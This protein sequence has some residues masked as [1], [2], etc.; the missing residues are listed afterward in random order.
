MFIPW[1][2][3][4]DFTLGS[5]GLVQVTCKLRIRIEPAECLACHPHPACAQ[6]QERNLDSLRAGVRGQT[7]G[8]SS[9]AVGAGQDQIWR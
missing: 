4:L 3:L 1:R 8:N 7:L 2:C 6:F 9:N 5:E